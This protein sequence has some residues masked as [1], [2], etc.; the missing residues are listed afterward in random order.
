MT[1]AEFRRAYPTAAF[2]VSSGKPFTYRYHQNPRTKA[3]LIR[4]VMPDMN[5]LVYIPEYRR[6][7]RSINLLIV[8]DKYKRIRRVLRWKESV[9]H[10][11]SF[12]S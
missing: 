5:R 12:F 10:V 1:L 8:C 11:V 7:I 3:T 6:L 4:V 2:T 9:I